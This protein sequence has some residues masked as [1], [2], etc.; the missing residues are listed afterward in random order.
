M[1]TG[2]ATVVYTYT[3]DENGLRTQKVL[4]WPNLGATETTQY[5]YNGS[6][7]IGM[8]VGS[9]VRMRFSYDASGN[10][11]AVDYS[12]DSGS[13][14]TT[15]YYVRNAQNDVVKL[16][17]NSGNAVVEYTY[18]SWGKV[19]SSTSSLTNGLKNNQPFRYRGYVYDTETGFYYLQSRYYD[20]T[21]CRFISADVLLSTGQGVLGHNAFAYCLNMPTNGQD[22]DGRVFCPNN[23]MVADGGGGLANPKK[24]RSVIIYYD[25]EGSNASL[26]NQATHFGFSRNYQQINYIS[27]STGSE[28]AQALNAL[29]GEID[30]IYILVHYDKRAVTGRDYD[31][32]SDFDA[33]QPIDGLSGSIY[34]LGCHGAIISGRL[35]SQTKCDVIS[36]TRGVSY[37]R[38]GGRYYPTGPNKDINYILHNSFLGR[39]AIWKTTYYNN[40]S[41][42]NTY[43]TIFPEP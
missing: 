35:S 6:V 2:S 41:L 25:F 40:G 16:I 19:I 15:Y 38:S 9:D 32:W 27:F 10:V 14:F 42:F 24:K 13:T 39:D 28:M 3:Y 11:A 21:T 8:S 22:T 29:S 7:L 36:C 31:Q 26:K 37:Y 5:F 20:P 30:D 43:S 17:D 34:F 4:S 12:T 1:G 33:I 18:D 23:L